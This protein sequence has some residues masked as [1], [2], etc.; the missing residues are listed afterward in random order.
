MLNERSKSNKSYAYKCSGIPMS[1]ID[2]KFDMD[3][4]ESITDDQIRANEQK[5]TRFLEKFGLTLDE[6]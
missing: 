3:K 5:I 4:P 6:D 1:P 2:Y